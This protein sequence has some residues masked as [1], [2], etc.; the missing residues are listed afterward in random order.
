MNSRTLLN[1]TLALLLAG[2]VALALLESEKN[3]SANTTTLTLLRPDA[4]Q[5]IRVQSAGHIDI[6]L[7][8]TEGHWQMLAP[9]S[10]PANQQRLTQLLK[11]L[12]TK[13]LANYNLEQTDTKQL[14][15]D[16]PTLILTFDE[17]QLDFGGTAPLGGSRYVR[18]N[19]TVHLITD[20]YSHLARGSATNLLSPA[21]LNASSKIT[22]LQ[23]PTLKVVLHDGQWQVKNNGSTET[24]NPD[25]L[26]QLL[27]EW[28]HAR[29]FNVQPL[30]TSLKSLA[31]ND[32]ETITITTRHSLL[33]FTLQRMDDEIIL[34]R[35]DLGL[36]YHFSQETG[37][38]LLTLPQPNDA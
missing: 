32:R 27:D 35:H 4:I 8:K 26:Q 13:S 23:L 34:Q 37:Q 20:R 28:R 18:I 31:S 11:V 3:E 2:L 24:Q 22:A 19:E 38:R 7:I 15:L 5:K 25:Q 29:A 12:T 6:N 33:R 16:T 36:Q 14:Q 10:A 1:L 30:D 17:T 9:F 21:L